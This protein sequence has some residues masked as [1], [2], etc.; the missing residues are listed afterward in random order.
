MSFW[1]TVG[2]AAGWL[3]GQLGTTIFGSSTVKV[4]NAATSFY[5]QNI[6][7]TF[8]E[9]VGGEL[10]SA[11][12][13]KAVGAIT[14]QGQ[15]EYSV[16]LPQGRDISGRSGVRPGNFTAKQARQLGLTNP[17]V[18]EAYRKA[19]ASR[20]RDIAAVFNMV[21]PRTVQKGATTTLAQAQIG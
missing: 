13:T 3:D 10:A 8:L 20:N 19:A 16:P 6:A 4:A 9:D 12:T 11:A 14:G 15:A 7:G 2:R 17:R 21:R 18:Q 1:G 5:R